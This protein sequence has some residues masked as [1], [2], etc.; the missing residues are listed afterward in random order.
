MLIHNFS[1]STLNTKHLIY[2]FECHEAPFHVLGET[3]IV[4][5]EH[6]IIN[7]YDLGRIAKAIGG[8]RLT[9]FEKAYGLAS[10]END[11]PVAYRL[12]WNHN[13]NGGDIDHNRKVVMS[14]PQQTSDYPTDC[15]HKRKRSGKEIN[16]NKRYLGQPNGSLSGHTSISEALS[17]RKGEGMQK[18]VA[19]VKDFKPAKTVRKNINTAIKSL[20][21]FPNE[22]AADKIK[23]EEF[24]CKILFKS[25]LVVDQV[26]V[27]ASPSIIAMTDLESELNSLYNLPNVGFIILPSKKSSTFADARQKILLDFDDDCL[28][29]SAKWKFYTPHLG[30]INLK[31]ETNLGAMLYFLQRTTQKYD[32]GN[33]TCLNL[34]RV[35]I[36]EVTPRNMT[37]SF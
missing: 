7:G 5:W 17:K 29:S 4:K 12:D 9:L 27:T 28:P 16:A 19:A 18:C 33:G 14:T 31:Q 6:G 26:K 37:V 24:F 30:P 8:I 11:K 32:C 35:I 1:L 2:F 21:C 36:C 25:K 13:C 23:D 22:I 3:K 20:G 34:L 10:L 15:P